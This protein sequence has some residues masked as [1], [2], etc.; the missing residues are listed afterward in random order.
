MSCKSGGLSK[1]PEGSGVVV[2]IRDKSTGKGVH[3]NGEDPKVCLCQYIIHEQAQ[4]KVND[5]YH[6]KPKQTQQHPTT[7]HKVTHLY[8]S[9]K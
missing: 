2:P 5:S 9:Y 1:R 3:P 6:C 7:R 8:G 4:T